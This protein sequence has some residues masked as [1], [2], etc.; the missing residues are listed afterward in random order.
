MDQ[1]FLQACE[2]GAFATAHETLLQWQ[3]SKDKDG[4]SSDTAELLNTAYSYNQDRYSPLV[5]AAAN[6]HAKL[7]KLLLDF[8]ACITYRSPAGRTRKGTTA[9][10]EAA[11]AGHANVLR[12]LLH[13]DETR[14][15]ELANWSIGYMGVTPLHAAAA[16]GHAEATEVLLEAGAKNYSKYL[17]ENDGGMPSLVEPRGGKNVSKSTQERLV[18]TPLLVACTYGHDEVVRLLL[19]NSTHNI[20]D[21]D[22]AGRTPLFIAVKVRHA[23]IVRQLLRAGADVDRPEH[24]FSNT[25]LHEAVKRERLDLVQELLAG[26]A[27]LQENHLGETPLFIAIEKG[28][29]AIV[30]TIVQARRDQALMLHRSS[31]VAVPHP[32]YNDNRPASK[33]RGPLHYACSFLNSINLD[34]VKLLHGMGAPVNQQDP[35][36]LGATPLLICSRCDRSACSGGRCKATVAEYLI[37]SGAD[38]YMTD[39]YGRTALHRAAQSGCEAM[40]QL[41]L[42]T[43]A[44]HRLDQPDLHH[45][46]TPL[47]FAVQGYS[48]RGSARVV[49]LLAEKGANVDHQDKSG[50]S[51]LHIASRSGAVDI[52]RVLLERNA[53]VSVTSSDGKTPLHVAVEAGHLDMV[54]LLVKH[55]TRVDQKDVRGWTPLAIACAHGNADLVQ[56]LM[57]VHVAGERGNVEHVKRL[58]LHT[59]Y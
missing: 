26:G 4:D 19:R 41:L 30:R 8:G 43:R 39:T 23:G 57:E 12:V 40:V 36:Y 52:V 27:E 21:C 9:I 50:M 53:Q 13:H 1:I 17:H 44:K 16:H 51:P 33:Q 37:Q 25:P 11:E 2:T 34:M 54:R 48:S 59:A 55:S 38:V 45:H 24:H 31:P 58:L 22:N 49:E 7:V 14:K 6:G 56:A 5:L 20:N 32:L 10:H 42:R 3:S 29:L 28:N 18:D 15:T 35:S 47:H 46:A